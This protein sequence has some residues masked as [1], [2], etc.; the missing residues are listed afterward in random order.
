[1]MATVHDG[2][3]IFDTAGRGD[4]RVESDAY[5]C[6]KGHEPVFGQIKGAM[7]FRRFSLRG[8]FEVPS[9]WGI[10]ATCHNLL[11]LF[12]REAARQLAIVTT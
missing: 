5:R 10:V 12:R 4:E 9:E 11:K 6:E 3:F 2:G 7:G 8:L 1:M